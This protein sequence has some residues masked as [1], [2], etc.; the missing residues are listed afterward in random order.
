[1]ILNLNKSALLYL[2]K[3]KV[4]NE[5]IRGLKATDKYKYLGTWVD[6][7]FD[8]KTHLKKADAKIS[9]ITRKFYTLRKHENLHFNVNLFKIFIAP[10]L[11]MISSLYCKSGRLIKDKV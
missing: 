2:N 8:P 9:F 6:Q 4:T 11:K 10:N 7:N 5:E 1:L 3:D